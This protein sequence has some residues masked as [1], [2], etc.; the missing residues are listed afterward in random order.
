MRSPNSPAIYKLMKVEVVPHNSQWKK[1]FEIE[2]KQIATAIG[3]NIVA[4]HHIGSTAIPTIYAKPII[5]FLVEVRDLTLV[6]KR[7]AAMETLEYEAMGEF[8]IK[9]RRYFRKDRTH[10][11]HIFE[12]NSPEITRHLAFRDYLIAHPKIALE[13]S[14]LKRKLAQ[15][16]P[17]DIEGYMDGKDGFI[18]ATEKKA[19]EWYC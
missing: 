2:S 18:K 11:V 15:Q 16:Y 9:N 17:E 12:V 3:K 14:D 5:D 19:V 4:I 7:N 1:A 6:D 8:G 13:Y 10:H